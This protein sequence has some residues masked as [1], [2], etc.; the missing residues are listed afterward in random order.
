MGAVAYLWLLAGMA[1][2]VGGWFTISAAFSREQVQR[3]VALGAG[4]LLGGALLT[5]L[6]EAMHSARGPVWVTLGYLGLYGARRMLAGNR[7]DGPAT[8]TAWAATLGMALH[9]FFDGAALGAAAVANAR[10]GLIAWGAVTLHKIPE[11][12]GLA[13]LVL[14]ATGSR[15][16]AFVATA[17][18]GVA[19]VAGALLAYGWAEVVHL[20]HGALLGIAAGSF[21]Y[22]GSTEM[23]PSLPR[24]ADTACLV[25]LGAAVVYLLSR[26]VVGH[27]H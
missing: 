18:V 5:L 26:G 11:G 10:V 15:R 20:P 24:R 3:V 16:L 9:S 14:S 6:P 13:A 25:M 19:T 12:F 23:L 4:F 2:V 27:V 8:D 21:L 1:N 22:V 17:A 7:E